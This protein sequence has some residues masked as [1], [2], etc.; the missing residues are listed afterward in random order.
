M[1]EEGGQPDAG[2]PERISIINYPRQTLNDQINLPD[3]QSMA[4]PTN[5]EPTAA[6]VML[7]A[8][9]LYRTGSA[10]RFCSCLDLT[11]GERMRWEC[12]AVC[13]WYGE[14]I[15]NRKWFIRHLAAGF[16]A[17]ACTPCQIVVPA[18]GK[19]PLALEL[20]DACGD[21]IAS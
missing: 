17:D 4:K 18:A 13:P 15:L 12:E 1:S 5:L 9:G 6:L 11:A 7:W 21:G 20:L 10:A 19:S 8:R 2:F 14:V 3:P 16:I